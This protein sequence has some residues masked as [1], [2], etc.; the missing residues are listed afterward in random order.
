M[1][2]HRSRS[3]SSSHSHYYPSDSE[4]DDPT[5]RYFESPSNYPI[6]SSV[7]MPPPMHIPSNMSVPRRHH[8]SRSSRSRSRSYSHYPSDSLTLGPNIHNPQSYPTTPMPI[9]ALPPISTIIQ[10]PSLPPHQTYA[11]TSRGYHHGR[12]L[13]ESHWDY[14][15]RSDRVTYHDAYVYRRARPWGNNWV[16]ESPGSSYVTL[17]VCDTV[18]V[19]LARVPVFIHNAE[20]AGAV[21]IGMITDFHCST[22]CL[23]NGVL[24]CWPVSSCP[25]FRELAIAKQLVLGLVLLWR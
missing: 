25:H 12:P 17:H 3:R 5:Q 15:P 7:A 16:S 19:L 1:S 14:D 11:V 4:L 21:I 6:T 13:Y 2:R 24:A 20:G 22:I 9:A 8:E 23:H 10:Q 18:L